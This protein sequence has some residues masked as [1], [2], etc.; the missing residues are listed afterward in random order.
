M[1]VETREYDVAVVEQDNWQDYQRVVGDFKPASQ[2]DEGPD[3]VT[4]SV[5]TQAASA[6]S[7]EVD[8]P[9]IA[10][11][12]K[13]VSLKQTQISYRGYRLLA[14]GRGRWIVRR[15]NDELVTYDG[16]DVF[17]LADAKTVANAD[18]KG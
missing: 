3:F 14:S 16:K 7:S 17:K 1:R 11:E 15:K 4:A 5:L 9:S 10:S 2:L 18:L 6:P 12:S 13:K 8:E